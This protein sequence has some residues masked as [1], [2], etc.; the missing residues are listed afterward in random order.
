MPAA[1][2]SEKRKRKRALKM[3]KKEEDKS[4]KD[5]KGS[6]SDERS[7]RIVNA[8]DVIVISSGVDDSGSGGGE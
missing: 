3:K 1:P 2:I 7:R 4:K 8:K 5:K 6:K